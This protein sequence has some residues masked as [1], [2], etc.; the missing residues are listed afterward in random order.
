MANTRNCYLVEGS[1]GTH[2]RHIVWARDEAQAK[3]IALGGARNIKPP[4]KKIKE[5]K[6]GRKPK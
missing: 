1:N 3:A 6:P 4:I 5:L 2:D